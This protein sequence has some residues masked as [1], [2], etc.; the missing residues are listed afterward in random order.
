MSKIEIVYKSGKKE[1]LET[2][3]H[4]AETLRKELEVAVAYK[5]SYMEVDGFSI[6]PNL[7]KAVREVK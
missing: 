2:E 5:K 3:S 6:F 1:T 7:I 4:T